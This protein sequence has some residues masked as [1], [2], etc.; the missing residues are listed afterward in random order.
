[1]FEKKRK[2]Q[3]YAWLTSES[4]VISNSGQLDK[5]VKTSKYS[6]AQKE[7]SILGSSSSLVM[8][9]QLMNQTSIHENVGSNPGLAQWVKGL[10]LP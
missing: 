6:Y 2:R 9:Q 4:C 1:M 8:A 3:E 7:T 10:A 5:E